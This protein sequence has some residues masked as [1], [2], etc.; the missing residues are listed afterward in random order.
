MVDEK[1]KPKRE[2][3][4]FAVSSHRNPEPRVKAATT[5]TNP[6]PRGKKPAKSKK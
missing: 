3:K 5:H 2:T 4:Y 6:E 1:K